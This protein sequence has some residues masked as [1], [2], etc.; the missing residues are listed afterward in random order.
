MRLLL[1][2]FLLIQPFSESISAQADGNY[3]DLLILHVD[4]RYKNCIKKAKKYIRSKKTTN[5]EFPYL[6]TSACYYRISLDQMYDSDYPDAQ[7]KALEYA[8]YAFGKC[9]DESVYSE[10]RNDFLPD[11]V[12]MTI[13]DI[14]F[15]F[16]E[17]DSLYFEEVI[18]MVDLILKFKPNEA[19]FYFIKSA[20]QNYL[21]DTSKAQL[22]YEKGKEILK[23]FDVL[24]VAGKYA[25]KQG[26][27]SCIDIYSSNS[28]Y[29]EA[30]QLLD[31]CSKSLS[32]DEE[33]LYELKAIESYLEKY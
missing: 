1:A 15:E 9:A 27:F 16:D 13:H 19:G 33:Y 26:V 17:A 4:G 18:S 21:N 5:D 29:S 8:G 23:T 22:S 14:R 6:V 3:T 31:L 7:K 25:L 28:N 12:D 2:F 10:F 24:S 20:C 30:K 32:K 11:L